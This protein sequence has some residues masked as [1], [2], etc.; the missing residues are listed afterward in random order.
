MRCKEET[1][2]LV[3]GDTGLH[4]DWKHSASLPELSALTAGDRHDVKY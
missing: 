2:A 4:V 1:A 3:S